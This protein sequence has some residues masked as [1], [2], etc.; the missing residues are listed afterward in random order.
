MSATGWLERLSGK[1][2]SPP[3]GITRQDAMRVYPT[4]NPNLEWQLDEEGVVTATLKRPKDLRNRVVGAF[5]MLPEARKLKLDEV[6]TF[7]WNLCDG[8]HTV[9]DL[10][11]AMAENYKLSRREVEVSLTEFLRMLAKRGMIVVAVPQDIIAS[12]DPE[13][14]KALGVVEVKGEGE[15]EG[16]IDK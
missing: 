16:E 15:A 13:I 5:L 11:G 8:E 10:V 3:P 7:I 9:A 1:K 4:R 12:L 2:S 6:G 14:V